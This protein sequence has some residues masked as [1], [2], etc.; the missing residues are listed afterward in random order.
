MN[1]ELCSS[2]PSL[3]LI[4]IFKGFW[5]TLQPDLDFARACTEIKEVGAEKIWGLVE[6]LS[7]EEIARLVAIAHQHQLEFHAWTI[8]N[9][10]S[11]EQEVRDTMNEHPGWLAV[12]QEGYNTRQKI[13]WGKHSWWCPDNK[14]YLNFYLERVQKKV[15]E[16]GCDG[17]HLDF[18]RYPDIFAY[19][20][21]LA[22][23]RDE[24][25]EYSFCYCLNCR[26]RYM[27]ETG[28]DPIEV[29]LDP[30]PAFAGMTSSLRKQEYQQWTQWRYNVITET[31]RQIRKQIAPQLKLSAAVF[32]TPEIGRKNVLQ[33]WPAFADQL[34]ELCTMIYAQKQW[35]KPITW[36]KEATELGLKEMNG[37]CKYYAGFG[38]PIEEMK[39]GEIRQGILSAKEAGADGVVIHHYPGI[40]KEQLAEIKSANFES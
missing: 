19:Q 32:P 30:I 40:S 26:G 39:P 28:V 29:P 31:V 10:V 17:L 21:R 1:I 12:S 8:N 6:T 20:D 15:A 34:D 2:V 11:Q 37:K 27:R 7:P 3:N 25:P 18:I 35:G 22:I 5:V 38:Y 13:L 33:D 23:P 36:V 16:T 14:E 4:M 24:V 9:L